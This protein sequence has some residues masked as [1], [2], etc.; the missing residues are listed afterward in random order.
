MASSVSKVNRTRAALDRDAIARA[1]LQLLDEEGLDALSMRRLAARLGVGTM[2]LYGY[3]RSKQELLDAA[4]GAA[5][6][7]V[8]IEIPEGGGLRETL[9]A[10]AIA[11]Q[12][13][14]ER[15][16]A[17]PQ[18]RAR[19]PIVQ[20]PAFAMTEVAMK[21]LLEAGFPPEEAARVFRVLFV[22]KFGSAV[23]G[24]QDT[25]PEE[26]RQV[27]AALHMLPE[28][29]FPAVTAAADGIAASVGGTE[30]F[31]FGLELL[32]DAIEAR[33]ARYSAASS[34]Q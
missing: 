13:M 11:T 6:A 10:H 17:L 26:H 32:L 9:R 14:L 18:I 33:A 31:E 16:P 4:V 20:A 19:Q 27:R 28:E 25:P 22:Y 21:A 8:D 24:R 7:E 15:H 23:V 1:A 29:D 5:A 3:F 30:Q 34:H 12:H 2:T